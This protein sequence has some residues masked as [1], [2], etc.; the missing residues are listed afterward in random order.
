MAFRG[1]PSKACERCRARRLRVSPKSGNRPSP[2]LRFSFGC[3][4]IFTVALVANVS[5]PVCHAE[6]TGIH[7]NFGFEMKANL[8]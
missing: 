6:D 3:S 5:E 2:E 8:L 4:A 1:K 7:S